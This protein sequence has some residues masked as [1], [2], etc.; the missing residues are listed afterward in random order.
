[1]NG[2]QINFLHEYFLTGRRLHVRWRRGEGLR[3]RRGL[4]DGRR[5]VRGPRPV[6]RR[7]H[8]AWRQEVQAVLRDVLEHGHAEARRR[9]RRVQVLGGEDRGGALQ[10]R[11]RG[12][13]PGHPRRAAERVH[14]HRGCQAE[15]AAE[16][17]HVY[18]LHAAA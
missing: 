6:R 4:R 16:E 12:D 3:R 1:M 17:G 8:R 11:R 15:G 9:R 18:T 14:L 7:D 13:D 10:G 2:I 5:D